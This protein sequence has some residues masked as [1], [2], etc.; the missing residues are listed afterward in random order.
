MNY[1]LAPRK[2]IEPVGECWD[3]RKIVIELAK[4]MGVDVPWQDIEAHNDWQLEEF[5]TKYKDIRSKPSQMISWP[6]GYKK[7]N[8]EGFRFKTPSGKIELYSS[9]LENH[10][11]DPLPSHI[12]PPQ[13]PVSTPEL[14]K[15]YPLI[16]TNYRSI[17]YTHSEFRQLPSLHEK[18]PEP[19]IEINPETA[20]ALGINEGDEVFIERPG[21]KEQVYM[22]A[23]FSPEMHPRVVVCLSHWWFL[24]K[25]GPEHGC[26]ESNINTIISTDP[27]YDLIA[28]NYQMRAVLCRVGK[29]TSRATK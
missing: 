28:M 7:Y 11:Y 21:F 3:D 8:E 14:Y 27:P 12:E 2:L 6:I 22:K 23:K 15:D 25:T 18:F 19:L 20:G 26:F 10:G 9:I 5:G 24:E 17:V 29:S 16:L 4:R 1:I 13:S